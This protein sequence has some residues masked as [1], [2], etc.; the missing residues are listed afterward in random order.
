M[1]E[2]STRAASTRFARSAS[3][4]IRSASAGVLLL[5]A[6][7]GVAYAVPSPQTL[8]LCGDGPTGCSIRLY[9]TPREGVQV[10]AAVTGRPSVTVPLRV[11]RVELAGDRISRLVPVGQPAPVQLNGHGNGQA[12]LAV[13]AEDGDAG[14]SFVSLGD[15]AGTDPA[16][17]VGSFAVTAGRRPVLLGDAYAEQK[18]VG[19]DLDLHLGAA[20]DTHRFAVEYR[21]ESGIW[22]DVTRPTTAPRDDQNHVSHVAYQVPRGLRARAYAFRLRNLSDPAA[23]QEW[24]VVPATNGVP[25]PRR[26]MWRPPAV[27]ERVA[28]AAPVVHHDATLVRA[29]AAAIGALALAGVA[30]LSVRARARLPRRRT[31]GEAV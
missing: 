9:G 31:P 13:P 24:S 4:G 17:L 23:P 19:Q 5:A 8:Q 12:P 28:G 20:V 25:Q 1:S 29:G 16:E 7:P 18:P 11:Y 2:L 3:V 6:V 26:T 21:D 30:A 27:G 14:W 10:T 22:R 15:V